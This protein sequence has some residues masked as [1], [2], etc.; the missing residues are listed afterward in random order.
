MEWKY[1]EFCA[2]MLR[3]TLH[4][5]VSISGRALGAKPNPVLP[6]QAGSGWLLL[7][8]LPP[9][10]GPGSTV[11]VS[12][13]LRSSVQIL[14]EVENRNRA[15]LWYCDSCEVSLD[16]SPAF[17]LRVGFVWSILRKSAM[18]WW[19]GG[20]QAR[21]RLGRAGIWCLPWLVASN[22]VLMLSWVLTLWLGMKW[23]QQEE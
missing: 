21:A 1:F 11:A 9:W 18:R 17:L 8:S 14:C 22:M 6:W 12:A 2:I 13:E 16:T 20:S 23:D 19:A 7:A 4:A 10:P 15:Q 5:P 3:A